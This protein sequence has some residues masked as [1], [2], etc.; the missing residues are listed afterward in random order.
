MTEV[1][2]VVFYIMDITYKGRRKAS[3]KGFL[4][5]ITPLLNLEGLVIHNDG[6][7]EKIA[8]AET[9]HIKRI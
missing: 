2:K 9:K 8:R 6:E 7:A 5:E 4:E 3:E 1:G